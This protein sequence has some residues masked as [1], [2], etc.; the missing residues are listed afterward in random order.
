MVIR[1]C[2]EDKLTSNV[3]LTKAT[4]ANILQISETDAEE[5]KHFGVKLTL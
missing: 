3:C 2:Y 4:A 5:Y 1:K